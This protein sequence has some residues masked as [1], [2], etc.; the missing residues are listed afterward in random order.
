MVVF[1]GSYACR[2]YGGQEVGVVPGENLVCA[3][4]TTPTPQSKSYGDIFTNIMG[5]A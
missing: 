5:K 1:V 2:G 4:Q 3:I